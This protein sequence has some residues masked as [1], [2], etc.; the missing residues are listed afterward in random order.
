MRSVFS[1]ED[2]EL[3]LAIRREE[4]ARAA[5]AAKRSSR[6]KRSAQSPAAQATPDCKIA[7]KAKKPADGTGRPPKTR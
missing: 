1:D 5:K 6:P 3:M 7:E 2:I 4:E